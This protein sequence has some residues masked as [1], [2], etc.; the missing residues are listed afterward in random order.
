MKTIPPADLPDYLRFTIS[1][2]HRDFPFF[3]VAFVEELGRLAVVVSGDQAAAVSFFRSHG[4]PHAVA[5]LFLIRLEGFDPCGD[6]GTSESPTHRRSQEKGPVDC[7]DEAVS[8]SHRG[9][10][11]M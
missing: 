2:T 7:S 9:G 8:Y 1:A 11:Y 3:I 10:G 5:H 6:G 4:Y